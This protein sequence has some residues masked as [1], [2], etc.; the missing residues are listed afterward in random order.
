MQL[1][2]RCP[3]VFGVERKSLL[4]SELLRFVKYFPY[5]GSADRSCVECEI[6]LVFANVRRLLDEI[7][8][9]KLRQ[10]FRIWRRMIVKESS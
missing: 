10:K 5:R 6:T 2:A 7:S 8:S 4:K 3:S 1:L 9:G